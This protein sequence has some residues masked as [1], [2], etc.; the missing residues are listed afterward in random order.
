M[1]QH[2]LRLSP[3]GKHFA[4]GTNS[5]DNGKIWVFNTDSLTGRWFVL[6]NHSDAEWYDDSMLA[7]T[8]GPMGQPTSVVVISTNS[9]GNNFNQTTVVENIGGGSAGITFDDAGNLYTGNGYKFYGPSETGVIK[10]FTRAKWMAVLQGND[11]IDF[12]ND[13]FV[14]VDLLSAAS[15]GFDAMGNLY[16]GGGEYVS[17]GGGDTNYSA[18]I[19][20]SVVQK[21]A[22][23][24]GVIDPNDS[25]SVCR[26]DPDENSENFYTVN[27]NLLTGELYL[28]DMMNGPNVYVYRPVTNGYSFLKSKKKNDIRILSYNV[29][30]KFISNS[31][32]EK[33]FERILSSLNPD[34]IVFQE[35]VSKVWEQVPGKLQGILGGEWYVLSGLPGGI[36][37][38][39]L[40]ARYPLKLVRQ[41]TEPPSDKWGVTAALIDLPDTQFQQDIY[42]MG[43]HFQ[44]LDAPIFQTQRQRAS[45]AIIS[46]IGD[47]KKNGGNITLLQNTPIVVAGDFNFVGGIE[48]ERTLLTGDIQDEVTF[49]ADTK[50]DW[51]NSD[52]T[53]LTPKDPTTNN[54]NTSPSKAIP[55]A[56]YDRFFYTDS[57][58]TGAQGF[59]V[60]TLN[61]TDELLGRFGLYALDTA[62]AS[63]HL[64]ITK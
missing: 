58:V 46:W 43:I 41:D 60:N 15:L 61:M 1:D 47:A 44:S 9:S 16:V 50:P 4:L 37:K 35:I 33:H 52:L 53:D 57:V 39:I 5:P 6:N 23:G 59:I 36:Y 30:G 56:R 24:A 28:T 25:T 51:D 29:E 40:V 10:S 45:D 32:Y 34:I 55:E 21:A 62:E 49:G 22:Q 14:I 48:P 31:K 3:D 2:F 8:S 64:P 11:P 17:G 27:S 42:V 63:D 54:T 13:G 18:V 7:V 20:G 26:I 19:K 12:E 38:N